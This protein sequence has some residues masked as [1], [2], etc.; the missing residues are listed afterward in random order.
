MDRLE[1]M[2]VLLAVVEAGTLSGAGRQLG[3]PLATVSRKVSDLE[4]H[5]KTQLLIRSTRQLTL[6]EAGRAYVVACKRILGDMLEA[7][8]AAMG[9]Y[10]APCGELVLAAPMVFGR[11][12][13][14]PVVCDFLERYPDIRARLLLSDRN[15]NL[16][17]DSV[18]LALRIGALPDSGQNA[19]RLGTIQR[20]V[21]ASPAYLAARGRPLDPRE[22]TAHRCVSFELPV[23]AEKWRFTIGGEQ[24]SV[25]IAPC[26]AANTAEA[27]VDAAVA[28]TGITCVLSYQ[29]E[30][31]LRAGQLELLLREF[32]PA[33]IPVS[34]LYPGQSHM[35]AKLRALLDFAI[36]RL[37][38]RLQ[39]AN[40]ALDATP[41]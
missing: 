31:A 22:L 41:A 2:Q 37:R 6:T 16:L 23:A 33:P 4:T 38:A 12:H 35:P 18:D 17:E 21:C 25:P 15:V 28:G 19:A 34:F 40:A 39:S 11:L 36:P 20:V 24:V 29:V 14:L 1:S 30:A 8:R 32:E 5:L 3:M 27:A 9:E 7:E 10:S 26:L 13:L